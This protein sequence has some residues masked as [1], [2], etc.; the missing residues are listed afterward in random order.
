MKS[1]RRG[2]VGAGALG[3]A[4][5]GWSAKAEA[6]GFAN[7][8]IG[9]E[10]GNV[11]AT[12]PTAL[13]WNPG[14]MGF[15]GNGGL[16]VY[17]T[18]ILRKVTWDHTATL[19]PGEAPE[20]QVANSG[21]ARL[22]NV[23]GSPA[24]GGTARIGNLVIGGGFFAPFGGRAHWDKNGNLSAA[25][26]AKYPQ[27]IDGVQRWFN[28]DA[29]LSILYFSVGAAYRLGPLSI[30]A[31][32]N[33]IYSKIETSQAKNQTG[34]GLPNTPNEGRVFGHFTGFDG[35]FAAGVMAELL[36]D[37][38]Y[39]GASYQAQ[40]SMGTQTL[41]GTLDLTSP[42][43]PSHYQVSFTQQLPDIIRAG[44]RWRPKKAP[45]E[46]RVFGDL[47]RWSVM[48]TQCVA[49]ESPVAYPCRVKPDG[50][51]DSGGSGGVQQN[52][53]RNW[54][55]T[56]GGRLGVSFWVK[57][58]IELQVGG[59][60]ETAAVPDSTMTPDLTDAN[61][62]QGTLGARFMLTESLFLSA[63]YTHVQFM[64]RDNTGLSTLSVV[65]GKPVQ[66]P[67]AN[68]DGGGKYQQWIGYA[69]GN[70]EALF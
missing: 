50:A 68:E 35:S 51:D 19:N 14:A 29:E 15:S 57:P 67:T 70:L 46:F 16:G 8:R 5:A 65:N 25:D 36:P 48:T 24:I 41:H 22:F 7:T 40:P 28:I 55:D 43:G 21:Q 1:F 39:L 49:L 38:L 53:R 20:A 37:Q 23:F 30:G 61:N 27:T 10:Q 42:F 32:G 69:S 6:A 18:L 47:T 60:Y 17:G 3:L 26:R 52:F 9:A 13:Y 34:R 66:V 64:T 56:Y 45:V 59:G 11:T 33:L 4:I 54:N 31:T 62:V 58:E 44:V 2:V 63:S 12:N